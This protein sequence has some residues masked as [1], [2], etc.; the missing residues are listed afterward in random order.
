MYYFG[1]SFAKI[2]F[3]KNGFVAKTHQKY[4]GDATPRGKDKAG[5]DKFENDLID[6]TELDKKM[7]ASVKNRIKI[8]YLKHIED[9]KPAEKWIQGRMIN[10][11]HDFIDS[12]FQFN[13]DPDIENLRIDLIKFSDDVLSFVELKG[14]TD[15]RLRNDDKRNANVPEIIEQM[16]KYKRFI[17]KYE[18]DI[19]DYYQRL[20]EIKMNLGLISTKKVFFELKMK[21]RLI[22]VDTYQKTT[23]GREKRIFEIKKLLDFHDIDYYITK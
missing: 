6:L 2:E 23:K 8:D 13:Q 12:E 14:I 20:L 5:K 16:E 15:N 7:I 4:L 3:N 22:I 18:A 19:R 21:P 11:N 9:E 1:G 10:A 17:I